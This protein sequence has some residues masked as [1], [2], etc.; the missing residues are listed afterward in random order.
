MSEQRCE[1]IKADFEAQKG[2]L[3][4][5]RSLMVAAEALTRL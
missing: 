3:A 1:E 2:D 5:A 4:E